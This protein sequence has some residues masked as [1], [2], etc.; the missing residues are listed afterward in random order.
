MK[1]NNFKIGQ[2]LFTGFGILLVLLA[3]VWFT[4]RNAINNITY[5]LEITNNVNSM[6]TDAQDAQAHALRYLIYEENSF[7]DGIGVEVTA[8]IENAEEAKLMMKSEANRTEVDSAI[9]AITSYQ[10]ACDELHSIRLQKVEA[11]Q[12]R[13]AAANEILQQ[14]INMITYEIDEVIMKQY[15]RSGQ[16]PIAL[17]TNLS[18][19]Q[20]IRNIL[21]RIDKV[22]LRY[23]LATSADLQ[24]ETAQEWLREIALVEEQIHKV[25]ELVSNPQVDEM[26]RKA[27]VGLEAYKD[28]VQNFRNLNIAQRNEQALQKQYAGET[29]SE[30]RDVRDGVYAYI[31]NVEQKANFTLILVSSIALILGMS[32]AYF[33]TKG[34]VSPIKGFGELLQ[35]VASGDLSVKVDFDSKDE[36]GDMATHLKKMIGSLSTLIGNIANGTRTVATSAEELSSVSTQMKSG[37]DNMIGQATSVASTTEQMSTNINDMAAAAEEMSVN[38]NEVAGAA[39]QMSANISSVSSSVEEMTVSI[40]QVAQDAGKARDVSDKAVVSA[41]SATETMSVLGESAKEI[42]NVTEVIKR[43]AEQTNL[44]ALNATI[45]AAGAGEAGKGF[46][47]V[48]NEIK[49]LANQSAQAADDIAKRIEGVQTNTGSAVEVINEVSGIINEI[50]ESVNSIASAV[51]QQS[52]AANEISSNV[53]QANSGATNIASSISEVAKGTSDVSKNS[54]EAAK[55]AND[56]SQNIGDVQNVASETG[57]GANQ[58]NVSA[59]EL[60]KLSGELQDM[61]AEFQLA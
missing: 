37:A 8:S 45:E 42:G 50:G 22:A 59:G 38:A 2:R 47:V 16:V 21:N 26:V 58:I 13:S 30:A 61:V 7:N 24:D 28:Q 55:G 54:G 20:E 44:L 6:L 1:V 51:E 32:I 29:M 56:V 39:E 49:E 14:T 19:M 31:D 57:S 12:H 10:A 15:G 23:Q 35:K 4:G 43:I 60:A 53:L 11:G 52:R 46:A 18:E 17:V 25:E 48:A 40:N 41:N 9:M 36:I 33:L 27:E 5:Q 3:A 34:I